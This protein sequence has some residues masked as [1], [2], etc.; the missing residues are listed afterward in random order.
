MKTLNYLIRKYLNYSIDLWIFY[1]ISMIF[2]IFINYIYFFSINTT[3]NFFCKN[4]IK[5]NNKF[6]EKIT[7]F[8]YITYIDSKTSPNN[9]L[10]NTFFNWLKIS[11]NSQIICFINEKK[12]DPKLI[13]KKNFG[14]KLIYTS[15]DQHDL[16][17]NLYLYHFFD[18]GIKIST[19]KFVNFI[20]NDIYLTNE[21]FNIIK[22]KINSLNYNNSIIIG[23][24]FIEK[25]QNYSNDSDFYFFEINPSPFNPLD[26]PPFLI[27]KPFWSNWFL[28]FL[29][30]KLLNINKIGNPIKKKINKNYYNLNDNY[31]LNNLTYLTNNKYFKLL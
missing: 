1:I 26:L 4:C 28:G 3:N 5:N 29:E 14:N 12:F 15:I 18:K 13:W 24:S 23:Q 27:N 9:D 21:W 19:S 11:P 8:T 2:F 7:E 17:N 10:K 25:F 6:K 20:N 30:N 22:E 16:K 31:I